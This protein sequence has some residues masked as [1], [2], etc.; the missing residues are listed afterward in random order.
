M[1]TD[2]ENRSLNWTLTTCTEIE[3]ILYVIVYIYNY[4]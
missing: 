4:I 3:S 1:I 2:I